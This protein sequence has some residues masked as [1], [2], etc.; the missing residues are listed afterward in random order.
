M[1]SDSPQAID[2]ARSI[3]FSSPCNLALNLF[4][5]GVQIF[6]SSS[7]GIWP[8]Y[9]HIL[10][11]LPKICTNANNTLLA[12]LWVGPKNPPMK[13]FL[14]IVL[15]SFSYLSTTGTTIT[16]AGSKTVRARIVM[17]IFDLPAKALVLCMKQ[18]NSQFGCHTCC[19]PGESL[20]NNSKVYPPCGHYELRTHHCYLKDA[21][22]AKN[23]GTA[24]RGVLGISPLSDILDIVI[25][26]PVDYMHAVFEGVVKKW[27]QCG[28]TPPFMPNRSTLVEELIRLTQYYSNKHRQLSSA[29]HPDPSTNI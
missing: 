9:L 27:R 20:P 28:L 24:V 10:N 25:S 18:F 5:D 16:S 15:D 6:S 8:V 17:G 23:T 1:G 22:K 26:L 21:E 2:A 19:H 11:L 3:F 29:A 14:N 13:L 4:T 7:T 12:G